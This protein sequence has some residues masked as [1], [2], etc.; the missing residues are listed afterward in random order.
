MLT[1]KEQEKQFVFYLAP[2]LGRTG[3]IHLID[4]NGI[5]RGLFTHCYPMDGGE[6]LCFLILK[7][8]QIALKRQLVEVHTALLS[9]LRC[10]AARCAAPAATARAQS[11]GSSASTRSAAQ[12]YTQHPASDTGSARP[13][14]STSNSGPHKHTFLLGKSLTSSPALGAKRSELVSLTETTAS[15]LLLR[16]GASV[17][18]YR[19]TLNP[20]YTQDNSSVSSANLR[21]LFSITLFN[22]KLLK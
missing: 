22:N 10:S 19:S 6:A 11:A 7:D 20:F 13:H 4:I 21:P 3:K 15:Q 2:L 12:P 5:L 17:R 9:I 14:P 1:E 16:A 18:I 8:F